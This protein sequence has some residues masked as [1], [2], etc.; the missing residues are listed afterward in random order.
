MS[1]TAEAGKATGTKGKNYNLITEQ[2]LGQ[3]LAA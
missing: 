1:S 2:R 3:A